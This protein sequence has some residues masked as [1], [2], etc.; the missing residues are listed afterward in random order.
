MARKDRLQQED[1]NLPKNR[2]GRKRIFRFD[3]LDV[4]GSF[5]TD[6]PGVRSAASQYGKK[7]GKIFACRVMT[8]K[9]IEDAGK[10]PR[11]RFAPKGKRPK[12]WIKVFRTH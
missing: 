2:A 5:I 9:E 4:G 7:H 8:D 3:Q 12:K 6:R 11:S 1:Y 10:L